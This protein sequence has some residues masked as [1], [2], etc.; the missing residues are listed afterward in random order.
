MHRRD[1]KEATREVR[2]RG[3]ESSCTRIH[4]EFHFFW[5]AYLIPG[6]ATGTKWKTI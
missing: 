6:A 4:P 1:G 3:F 2:G 5:V